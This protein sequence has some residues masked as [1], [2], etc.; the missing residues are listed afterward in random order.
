MLLLL[1]VLRAT[2]ILTS[3]L[4]FLPFDTGATRFSSVQETNSSNATSSPYVHEAHN[5]LNSSWA[6]TRH[7]ATDNWS[8]VEQYV[9][10]MESGTPTTTSTATSLLSPTR[11][12]G[13]NLLDAELRR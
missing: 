4:P 3:G 8:Q 1:L 12:M 6:A 2:S 9:P 7:P 13:E 5:Q 11:N 10:G